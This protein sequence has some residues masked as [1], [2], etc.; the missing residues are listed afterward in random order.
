MT[1]HW[2][3]LVTFAPIAA[4]IAWLAPPLHDTIPPDAAPIAA[5]EP[6]SVPVAEG[7]ILIGT[8]RG[9]GF[10]VHLLTGNRYSIEDEDGALVGIGLT[11]SE[12]A[13]QFP[14]LYGETQEML[15]AEPIADT[16]PYRSDV[17]F[18]IDLNRR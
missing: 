17:G 6:D 7:A 16:D 10:A 11:E 18:G 14:D 9:R 3:I 13:D 1:T 15:A 12:F 8:L 2:I 5:V 4:A